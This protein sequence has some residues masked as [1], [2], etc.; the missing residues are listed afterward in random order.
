MSPNSFVYQLTTQQIDDFLNHEIQGSQKPIAHA[1]F[2]AKTPG[3]SIHLYKSGKLLVQGKNAQQWIHF[4]L[5]PLLL[6]TK[7]SDLTTSSS[8]FGQQ[9]IG[10]DETGKGDYFGPLCLCALYIPQNL[11]K[12]FIPIQTAI[13]SHTSATAF[14]S[15]EDYLKHLGVKDSKKI[16]DAVVRKIAKEVERVSIFTEVVLHPAQYNALYKKIPNLNAMMRYLHKKNIEDLMSKLKQA[17]HYP[18]QAVM[19]DQFSK[20]EGWLEQLREKHPNTEITQETK[21][22]KHLSV[23]CAS[24]IA[25]ARFIKEMHALSEKAGTALGKGAGHAVDLCAKNLLQRLKTLHPDKEDAALMAPWVKW[26][27]SNSKKIGL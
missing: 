11:P 21:A 3:L 20:D 12:D 24:I 16:T 25:R 13:R 23:A 6:T 27:F 4:H 26:H 19:V 7:S 15:T 14:R 22:E 18:P 1:L 9:C 2:S 5:E 17:G 10:A 8:Q